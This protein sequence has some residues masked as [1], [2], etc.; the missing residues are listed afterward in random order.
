MTIRFFIDGTPVPDGYPERIA[1]MVADAC[2]AEE[3]LGIDALEEHATLA[4]LS[5]SA[6]GKVKNQS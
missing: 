2:D 1:A 6:S 4:R 5:T 3:L